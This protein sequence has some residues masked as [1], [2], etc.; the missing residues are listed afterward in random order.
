MDV[1][2]YHCNIVTYKIEID[3]T[4]N[5]A[6]RCN[7][8]IIEQLVCYAIAHLSINKTLY[9]ISFTTPSLAQINPILMLLVHHFFV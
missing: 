4:T 2:F 8:K 6:L 5:K 3:Y 1:Y 7:K 9:R